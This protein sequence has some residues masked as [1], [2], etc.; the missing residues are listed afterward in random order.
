M[1]DLSVVVYSHAPTTERS[2]GMNDPERPNNRDALL[3]A[4]GMTMLV[5]GIGVG[6]V[7]VTVALP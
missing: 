3:W 2:V 6:I 5:V 1:W 7:V 4:L